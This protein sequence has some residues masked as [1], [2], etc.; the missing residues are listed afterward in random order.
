MGNGNNF[1]L[2]SRRKVD[3]KLRDESRFIFALISPRGSDLGI[4]VQ[5][6]HLHKSPHNDWKKPRAITS[7]FWL[8][9]TLI[10]TRGEKKLQKLVSKL[11]EHFFFL[12][13]MRIWLITDWFAPLNLFSDFFGAG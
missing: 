4:D 6:G 13:Y 8:G 3:I 2:T 9:M 1:W 12:I 10:L 7:L 5:N 11:D